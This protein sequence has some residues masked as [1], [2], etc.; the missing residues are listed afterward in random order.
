MDLP[1]DTGEGRF[2]DCGCDTT[3]NVFWSM[4]IPSDVAATIKEAKSA[5]NVKSA[6]ALK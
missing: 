1:V 5:R 6:S 3:S 4:A 2:C